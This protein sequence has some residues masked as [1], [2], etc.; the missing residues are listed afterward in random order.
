MYFR[1]LWLN[2]FNGEDKGS[3]GSS[4]TDATTNFVTFSTAPISGSMRKAINEDRLLLK[5][6]LSS[7]LKEAKKKAQVEGFAKVTP[8]L[9][10]YGTHLYIPMPKMTLSFLQNCGVNLGKITTG[11]VTECK[12]AQHGAHD[13]Y[14]SFFNDNVTCLQYFTDIMTN[15]SVSVDRKEEVKK[16]RNNLLEAAKSNTHQNTIFHTDSLPYSS[17]WD[18]EEPEWTIRLNYYIS[19]YLPDVTS[20]CTMRS[21]QHFE[22]YQSVYSHSLYSSMYIFRGAPDI[23]I[24]SHNKPEIIKS[25]QPNMIEQT[26]PNLLPMQEKF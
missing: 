23:I 18:L 22:D 14:Y 25:I 16:Y 21:G 3:G 6:Q 1:I 15:S 17:S 4:K 19:L 8:G 5:T 26:Q 11:K 9:Y 12:V 2:L 24:T 10:V 20:K 7:I 13:G